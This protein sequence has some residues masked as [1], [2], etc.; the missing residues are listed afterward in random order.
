[1]TSWPRCHVAKIC[2]NAAAPRACTFLHS[3]MASDGTAART[4]ARRKQVRHR[5]TWQRWRLFSRGQLPS[6]VAIPACALHWWHGL[7]DESRR[8]CVQPMS[9]GCKLL[10]R[11][12]CCS[13]LVAACLHRTSSST[14][15]GAIT[16]A[17][18]CA[19]LTRHCSPCIHCPRTAHAPL[20]S[21][22]SA[23]S[24]DLSRATVAFGRPRRHRHRQWQGH[25]NRLPCMCS[26][27]V[28]VCGSINLRISSERFGGKT[29][30][31]LLATSEN[32]S[33]KSKIFFS[34]VG[35]KLLAVRPRALRARPLRAR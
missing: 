2:L 33:G 22:A 17:R 8:V 28:R 11:P 1:M 10:A 21:A 6:T 25:F 23:D 32:A 31:N 3:W 9:T 13:S 16:R 4:C 14:R 26:W 29:A 7:C 27:C 12:L 5:H 20:A 35:R 34:F 30:L 18:T 24:G 19:S 15:Q